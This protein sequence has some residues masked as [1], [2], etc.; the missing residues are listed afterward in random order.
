MEE[1]LRCET[2]HTLVRLLGPEQILKEY[3]PSG[4]VSEG[5]KMELEKRSHL[6]HPNLLSVLESGFEDGR[7]R[8]VQ[9]ECEGSTLVN[10]VRWDHEGKPPLYWLKMSQQ[11]VDLLI[12]LL[13]HGGHTGWEID[14]EHLMVTDEKL[15]LI[16]RGWLFVLNGETVQPQS[17]ELHYLE[18]F[19]RVMTSLFKGL[20]DAGAR[21][22]EAEWVLRREFGTLQELQERIEQELKAQDAD[23][24]FLEAVSAEEFEIPQIT[25]QPT[26]WQA[27]LR[28][29]PLYL[30][31]EFLLV[32]LLFLGGIYALAP[33]PVVLPPQVLY[34]HTDDGIL[35][36]DAETERVLEAWRATISEDAVAL[37]DPAIIIS[38]TGQ[39]PVLKSFQASTG[40][41]T[42]NLRLPILS[43]PIQL[44]VGK[45]AFVAVA[46]GTTIVVEVG[47]EMK[48][49]AAIPVG[50][51]CL[52][53]LVG[54]SR[55]YIAEETLLRAYELPSGRLL[56]EKTVQGVS[57]LERVGRRLALIQSETRG[58]TLLD[59]DTLALHEILEV[60]DVPRKLFSPANARLGY[61]SEE[62]ELVV[63]DLETRTESARRVVDEAVRN[64]VCTPGDIWMVTEGGRLLR[65]DPTTLE[66]RSIPLQEKVFQITAPR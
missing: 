61:L 36:F 11:L 33:T 15:F 6:R 12:F 10:L 20:E 66:L 49:R 58:I 62:G 28:Q 38:P 41:A 25:A 57:G 40:E 56:A 2:R 24:G 26:P 60:P 63:W 8:L 51:T 16:D 64:L 29:P 1:V 21:P 50:K 65:A 30:L 18:Q 45:G 39:E 55:L 27:F 14:P 5:V 17:L 4:E 31:S 43:G 34:L 22:L 59:S 47:S 52:S 13:Q 54:D 9:A 44:A 37:R 32:T 48:A 53:L 46:P 35:I 19:R 7:Y 23:A 3:E 42:G